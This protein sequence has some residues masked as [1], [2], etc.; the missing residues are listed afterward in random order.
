[1]PVELKK[2]PARRARR[3]LEQR[4]EEASRCLPQPEAAG[5]AQ[6]QPG[7]SLLPE[8]NGWAGPDGWP[9]MDQTERPAAGVRSG[10]EPR[11]AWGAGR[12]EPDGHVPKA[13]QVAVFL[14]FTPSP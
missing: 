5:Q 12:G 1:M 10:G 2:S 9:I 8:L 3:F 11:G 14:F 4:A 6:R 13:P 7:L